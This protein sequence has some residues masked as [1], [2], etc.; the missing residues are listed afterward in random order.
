MDENIN[1][2]ILNSPI[3]AYARH[4]IILDDNGQ[5]YDYEFL[6]VNKTF[7]KLTGLTKEQLINKTARQ[8]LPG[9][10]NSKFDWINYYGEI[11][12]RRG[13]KDFEQYS[14]PL[15]KWYL[16][17]VYS[18]E[19]M[20]FTTIFI[21]ITKNKEK[22]IELEKLYNILEAELEKA[23]KLHQKFLPK[24]LPEVEGLTYEMK[25]QNEVQIKVEITKEYI[26]AIISDE[27]E[28]F[29]WQAKLEQ[30]LDIQSDIVNKKERGRGIK[31]A[32]KLYDGICYNNK[33][34]QVC[35]F[36]LRNK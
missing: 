7:E 9:I 16:V 4:K 35:L 2:P 24:D 33:G 20:Y 22:N 10:E 34:N 3:L 15:D 11:A 36:K 23:R 18:T 12:L 30:G 13:E 17:Y 28:G 27:G 6:E 21:D 1:N 25:Y 26:K 29:D 19:K 8:A 31:I 5:P 32:K 14:E